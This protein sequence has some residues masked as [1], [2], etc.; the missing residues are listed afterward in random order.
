MYNERLTNINERFLSRSS[1]YLMIILAPYDA[2]NLFVQILK[3]LL[4]SNS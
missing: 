1:T 4:F 3:I 2:K